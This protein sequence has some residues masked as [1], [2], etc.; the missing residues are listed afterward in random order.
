MFFFVTSLSFL[1]LRKIEYTALSYPSKCKCSKCSFKS[2]KIIV[3]KFVSA[4]KCTEH[5]PTITNLN[6]ALY[7]NL[8]M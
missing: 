7:N 6:L 5:R 2:Y 4:I 1:S 8:I 3:Y